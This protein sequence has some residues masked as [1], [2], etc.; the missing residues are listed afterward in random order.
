GLSRVGCN[1]LDPIT[2]YC[3][4]TGRCGD[5]RQGERDLHPGN[6]AQPAAKQP[7]GSQPH[8]EN[9]RTDAETALR[10]E[11]E[12]GP[13]ILHDQ[14]PR[15]PALPKDA[16]PGASL[17]ATLLRR[18]FARIYRGDYIESLRESPLLTT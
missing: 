18:R 16:P 13:I 7:T 2:E 3:I 10:T 17:E 1:R 15:S 12:S 4:G 5:D 9:E 8:Q 11:R 6:S 14:A